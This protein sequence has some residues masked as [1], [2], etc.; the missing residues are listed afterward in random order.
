MS[1]QELHISLLSNLDNFVD[2]DNLD[3]YLCLG[4]I[5]SL[6]KDLPITNAI[7]VKWVYHIIT[8]N[9]EQH[10]ALI[11]EFQYMK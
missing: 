3:I 6:K 9:V 8:S 1:F 5:E 2:M 7:N 10:I 4:L 11:V